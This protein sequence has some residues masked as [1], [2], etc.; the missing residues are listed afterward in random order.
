MVKPGPGLCDGSGV[1]EHADSSWDLGKI[2][3][4]DNS[5]WLVIDAN[6]EASGAPVDKLDWSLGLDSSNGCVDVFGDDISTVQHAAGHVL[7]M[8]GI[9]LDH[10]IDGLKAGIGNFGDRK[11]LMVSFLS[12]DDRC[13]S[14][15]REVDPGVRNQVGLEFGKIHIESSVKA[16]W[17]SD[18]G[19]NLANQ[20]VQVG[21][22]WAIN[23]QVTT[24][25]VVDG[26]I[27]DHKRAVAVFQGGVGRQDWVVGLN[28]S[29]GDLLTTIYPLFDVANF[30]KFNC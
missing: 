22:G 11:L 1:G 13:I 5:W 14:D 9:A 7:A 2:S 3:A 8:A 6:L 25:D 21:V 29:S 16:E 18:W 15:Q 20:P 27:V 4:G 12:R 19:D 28:N 23:I 30:N 26:L 10:L 17:G 24:A